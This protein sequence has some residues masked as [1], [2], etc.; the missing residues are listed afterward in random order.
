MRSTFICFL[1]VRCAFAVRGSTFICF[2]IPRLCSAG[3]YGLSSMR[4]IAIGHR[5]W[6]CG[7]N[8]K[9]VIRGS[10]AGI[11][12]LNIHSADTHHTRHMRHDWLQ[13]RAMLGNN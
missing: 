9:A 2:L 8:C 12:F 1:G 7:R 6:V 5:V 4:R 3:L 10:P 13:A 11:D